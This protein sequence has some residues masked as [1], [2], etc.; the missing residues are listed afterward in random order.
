MD[1]NQQILDEPAIGSIHY[2]KKSPNHE[3]DF[4]LES[5]PPKCEHCYA[6]E[7]P[8]RKEY[9]QKVHEKRRNVNL[10]SAKP[11]QTK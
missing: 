1:T 10:N 7:T 6:T 11:A 2:C 8:E 4:T 5:L 3:H 9:L